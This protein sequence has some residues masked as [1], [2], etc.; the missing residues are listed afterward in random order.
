MRKITQHAV[1]ALL[2]GGTFKQ[3]NTQVIDGDMYLHGNH[4]AMIRNDGTILLT[5]AGLN[6]T[7]TRERL[8]GVL[9]GL[10]IASKFVQRSHEPKLLTSDNLLQDINDSAWISFTR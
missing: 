7:T 9:Q 1:N 4:I 6:T 10:G 8:N 2:S 3:G 5:L